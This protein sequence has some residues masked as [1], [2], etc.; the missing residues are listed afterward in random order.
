MRSLRCSS[1]P[2]IWAAYPPNLS[3]RPS[4]SP[5]AG[6][7]NGDM[8][9]DE[10]QVAWQL[11]PQHAPVVAS[12]G[13]HI[14]ITEELLG[15]KDEDIFHGV[16]I[17]RD[18]GEAVEVPAARVTRMTAKQVMTDLEANEAKHLPPYKGR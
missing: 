1:A 9:A 12:D 13:S 7:V 3:P 17:R 11:M 14:G 10:T 18:D 8:S 4:A 5:L 15:D 6:I 2:P 16:V